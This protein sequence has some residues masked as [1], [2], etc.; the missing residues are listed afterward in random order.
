MAGDASVWHDGELRPASEVQM[1]MLTHTLHYGFGLFEGIRAYQ[2]ADGSSAVF[3]LREHVDRMIGG[4]KILRLALPFDRDQLARACVDT[5]VANGLREAYLRP[6]AYIGEGKM[7]IYAPQ[8]PVHVGV[9]AWEWG[10][11]LGEDG[12]RKGIRCK[13][14][15]FTRTHVNTQM[16]RAKVTGG[17]VTSILAK[18]EAAADGYDEAILLDQDGYCAEGSGENLFCVRDGVLFTPP[19]AAPILAGITRDAILT[20]AR[21]QGVEVREERFSRDDLYLADEAFF[22]GTAA[23]VTPIRE[24]DGRPVGTGSPGP[25][26]CELQASFFRVLRGEEPAHAAWRTVY[27][28]S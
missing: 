6:L 14:S 16:V 23:E 7:G 21:E 11:Y 4:A 1:G 10:A 24:V 26:T 12:L 18:S 19:L 13:V 27:K 25:V 15:S 9:A 28:V 3:R 5:L 22:T 17:Y 2:Q 8:N 20:L